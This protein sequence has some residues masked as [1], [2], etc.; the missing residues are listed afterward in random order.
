LNLYKKEFGYVKGL[1]IDIYSLKEL[2]E[3]E[4]RNKLNLNN[5]WDFLDL[6]PAIGSFN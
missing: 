2:T 5:K 3:L 6:R 4:I 1:F